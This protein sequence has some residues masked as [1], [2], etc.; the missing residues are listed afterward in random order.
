MHANQLIHPIAIQ[1]RSSV[2]DSYG[3]QIDEWSTVAEVRSYI[4][5]IGGRERLAGMQIGSTLTHTVGVRYQSVLAPPL[6]VG[7]WRVKFGDRLLNITSA[8]ILEEKNKW[9]IL[10]C[11]E[12]SENGQ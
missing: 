10:D 11:I 2:Q 8:R 3:Q 7:S 12:G 1:S 9:I 6:D 5:P 4:R